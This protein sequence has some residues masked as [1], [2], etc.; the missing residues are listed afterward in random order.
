METIPGK[1]DAMIDGSEQGVRAKDG[2][3][4]DAIVAASALTQRYFYPPQEGYAA[5]SVV[6]PDREQ[7]DLA[8]RQ[9]RTLA[10]QEEKV[11]EKEKVN[12]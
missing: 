4:V 1:K 10:Q 11:E 6:A 8:Y 5:I 12:E 7:A 3:E 2:T 9:Q